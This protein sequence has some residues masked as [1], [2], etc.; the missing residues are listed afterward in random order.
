MKDRNMMPKIP[1]EQCEA[2]RE[3]VLNLQNDSFNEL[4][5]RTILML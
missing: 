1:Q 4:L 2:K 3:G 5:T